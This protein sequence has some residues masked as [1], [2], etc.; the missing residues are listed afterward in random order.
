MKHP[1]ISEANAELKRLK[2]VY[3]KHQLHIDYLKI[4]HYPTNLN[5]KDIEIIENAK[6]NA[7]KFEGQLLRKYESAIRELRKKIRDLN[8]KQNYEDI[9]S[10]IV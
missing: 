2:E 1:E 5:Y 10:S 9:V 3:R 6:Q 4:L 7:I 8:R